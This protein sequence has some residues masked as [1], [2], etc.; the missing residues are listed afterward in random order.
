MG[1]TIDQLAHR[2]GMSSRNIR[3]WQ[4]QGL[5]AP[6]ARRGRVGIYSD[7]HAARI[8]RV[9]QL[10]AEGF[11]LDLIR[12]MIDARTGSETDIRHLA[13]ELLTPFSTTETAAVPRHELDRR[14]GTAAAAKLGALGLIADDGGDT[15]TVRDTKMLDLIERL[16]GVGVS[17]D[18]LVTALGEVA[19]HQRAIAEAILRPYAEDVWE[20]FVSSKFATPDFHSLADNAARARPVTIRLLTHM[21][22][23]A[24]DHVAGAVMLREAGLTEQALDQLRGD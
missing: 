3:E 19:A 11:P 4:R 20:P 6:P 22:Q 13:D 5:L 12:R 1:M 7:E 18:R 8:E 9:K 14:L 17:L 16:V 2:V 24:L 23:G 15:I 10:H 21:Q